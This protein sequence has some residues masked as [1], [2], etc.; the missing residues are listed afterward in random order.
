[1]AYETAPFSMTLSNDLECQGHLSVAFSN[2]IFR[3]TACSAQSLS[4]THGLLN[5][6]RELTELHVS[7]FYIVFQKALN[8]SK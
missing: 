8:N 6:S 4:L 2:A 5:I 7:F 1:M 3:A